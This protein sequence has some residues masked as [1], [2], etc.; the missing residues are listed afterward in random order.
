MGTSP[1]D[2]IEA[3]K[4]TVAAEEK[5]SEEMGKEYHKKVAQTLKTGDAES[6][7]LITQL[8]ES[9]MTEQAEELEA[10]LAAHQD[11]SAKALALGEMSAPVD[12]EKEVHDS[13]HPNKDAAQ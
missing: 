10:K 5:T 3:S 1:Q 11:A 13:A 12:G 4:K 9:G 7:A 8:R 6:L 2:G